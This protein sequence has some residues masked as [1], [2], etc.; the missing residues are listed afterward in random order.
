MTKVV[1]PK[2]TKRKVLEVIQELGYHPSA[3]ARGLTNK[4]THT[5]GVLVPNL[6]S[7]L[8]TEFF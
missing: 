5:I 3:I 7:S 6:T 4:R 2:K 8:V 1:I